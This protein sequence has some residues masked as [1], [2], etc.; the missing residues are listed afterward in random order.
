MHQLG[1]HTSGKEMPTIG[2]STFSHSEIP[3]G[4]QLFPLQ[5]WL[6]QGTGHTLTVWSARDQ[7]YH[8]QGKVMGN[9]KGIGHTQGFGHIATGGGQA[10]R[11]REERVSHLQGL[12]CAGASDAPQSFEESQLSPAWLSPGQGKEKKQ[13]A[14]SSSVGSRKYAQ[15]NSPTP[16]YYNS[17][18]PF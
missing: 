6:L 8:R 2:A 14:T 18:P 4:K 5:G 17:I 16:L 10:R 3:Q 15:F 1:P 7:T 12:W 9:Y 11:D 13:H